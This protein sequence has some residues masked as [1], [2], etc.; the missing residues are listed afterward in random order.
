MFTHES[1]RFCGRGRGHQRID[2]DPACRAADEGHDGQVEV[3]Y[4][5]DPLDH[6][7]EP[8]DRQQLRLPPQTRVHRVGRRLVADEAVRVE[9]ERRGPV[10]V[11]DHPV[12]RVGDEAAARVLEIGVVSERELPEKFPV[13]RGGVV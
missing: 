2:H 7:E 1:Q 3:A 4:L 10:R 12:R 13:R 9:V 5:V 6:L 11:G 8:G